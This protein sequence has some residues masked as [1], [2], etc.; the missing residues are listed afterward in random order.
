MLLLLL[1]AVSPHL[2]VRDFL[3][4]QSLLVPHLCLQRLACNGAK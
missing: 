3:A 1:F 4:K 2:G